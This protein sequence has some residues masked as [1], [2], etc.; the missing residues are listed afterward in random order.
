MR[1]CRR[2]RGWQA[3]ITHIVRGR[4]GWKDFPPGRID[5]RQNLEGFASERIFAV[6][7]CSV[8]TS[9]FVVVYLLT[10]WVRPGSDS[11]PIHGRNSKTAK[12]LPLRSARAASGGHLSRAR[13]ARSLMGWQ[14]FYDSRVRRDFPPKGNKRCRRPEWRSNYA[15]IPAY[16]VR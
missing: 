3:T 10:R 6:P 14:K 5:R 1:K 11:S 4:T 9:L 16:V 7:R 12:I 8:R 2:S 13:D 15:T